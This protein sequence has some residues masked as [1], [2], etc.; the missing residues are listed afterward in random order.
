[1]KRKLKVLIATLSLATL[2]IFA[3][4]CSG[5]VSASQWWEQLTCKH[6]YGAGEVTKQSTCTENGE[7]S[8]TCT[9]CGN[10]KT[11][12]LD[13][14]EHTS[15]VV[16]GKAA[17]C[18]EKGLTDGTKC[19]I[20]DT[21]LTAQQEIPAVGHLI[22]KDEATAATC[23]KDG[24]TA[25]EHCSVCFEVLLEQETIAAT[26]HKLVSI[27]GYAATCTKDGKTDEIKCSSCEKIYEE[28]KVIT[29][30]GHSFGEYV[31]AQEATCTK[32]GLEKRTCE[33]CGF[34]ETKE[35]KATGIHDVIDV[36]GY[37]ATCTATGLTPGQKCSMCDTVI[38]EQEV[39][40]KILHAYD[41][42]NVVKAAT[43]GTTGVIRYTC[44]GCNVTKDETIAATG[45]HIAET[46][47]GKAATCTE[48]GLTNGQKCKVC[49]M[50]LTAQE[51]IP[52]LDHVYDNGVVTKEAT[53]TSL[54]VKTYTCMTC[55]NT[56]Y[57]NIDGYG[58]HVD[59]NNNG[60]CDNCGT[61][62]Y[63]FVETLNYI[64]ADVA[65]EEA[66]AGNWYRIYGNGSI[67]LNNWSPFS[68]IKISVTSEGYNMMWFLPEQN[69][70]LP[71]GFVVQT[72]RYVDIFFPLGYEYHFVYEF[73]NID[74]V[75]AIDENTKIS[76]I[77]DGTIIKRLVSHSHNYVDYVCTSCG[78]FDS[79]T[80][81]QNF[82]D[83][84]NYT[85]V[86]YTDTS[87][88]SGVA[89]AN[90]VVR[91]YRRSEA[92][93]LDRFTVVVLNFG[94]EV[95]YVGVAN[96]AATNERDYLYMATPLSEAVDTTCNIQN[97]ISYVV[98]DDY[99]DICFGIGSKVYGFATNEVFV[100][101]ENTTF[102]SVNNGRVEILTLNK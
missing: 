59:S 98:Y 7:I 44:T 72:D 56:K 65:V 95:G 13:L 30:Y 88:I 85:S 74:S 9:E 25:G 24:K 83:E 41:S 46:V 96:K 89:A 62:D 47:T 90:K 77:D 55:G 82:Q 42:G 21:V 5:D 54:A 64:E 75:E 37:P 36:N 28:A 49:G 20:C 15:I 16:E 34:A 8:Y 60:E 33:K 11:E 61:V 73:A 38:V 93:E 102:A 66:V 63:G 78:T 6:T 43:C 51:N 76:V 27:P 53:C 70:T 67:T 100:I 81:L 32:D 48:T 97:L 92:E 57:E 79:M 2:T 12:S 94:D 68:P 4:G 52:M 10:V 91:I 22:V 1:M 18:T 31:I 50:V 80:Y 69:V 35:I 14:A 19:Y 39:L 17:T 101:D 45:S 87:S 71:E 23:T 40:P 3:A 26:G 29:A 99:I 86:E 84:A 58:E